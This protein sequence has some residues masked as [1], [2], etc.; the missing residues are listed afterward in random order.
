MRRIILFQ[1]NSTILYKHEVLP[2][3]KLKHCCIDA[4]QQSIKPLIIQQYNQDFNK[5]VDIKYSAHDAFLE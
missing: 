4:K 3:T 2:S 1:T 5:N